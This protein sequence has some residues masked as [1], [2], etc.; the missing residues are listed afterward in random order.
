MKSAI[1]TAA[2]FALVFAP[3]ASA[4]PTADY[5]NGLQ[6]SGIG[7][8]SPDTAMTFGN[9]VCEG[10]RHGLSGAKI[11]SAL[12]AGGRLTSD[13]AHTIIASATGHLCPDVPVT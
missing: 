12:T 7:F 3:T 4:D 10:F 2:A 11:S 9:T 6:A 1:C 5:L 8:D 13:Q